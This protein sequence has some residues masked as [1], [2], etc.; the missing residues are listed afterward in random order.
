AG[1]FY[2]SSPSKLT[3]Q[4][5]KYLETDAVKDSAIGIVS[6][7]AGLMYSGRVAGAVYSRI[8]IPRTFILIGPNHTGLG[9]P[10]S[11]MS[12][13]VWHMP[14]GELKIDEDLAGAL[15]KTS[16]IISED[17]LAHRMEHSLEVQLPF[18][19]HFSSDA[20]IVPITMMPVQL[21][22]CRTVGEALADVVR[23]SDY[24][25]TIIASSDMSHYVSDAAAR[26][27]D[28][29]AIDRV[30]A[31]DPEGLYKTVMNEDISM[32]GVIPV[33]TMLFAARKLGASKA[34]LV[35]YM[36]SGEV[37]GDYDY[38]VGYAGIIVR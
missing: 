29:K 23:K 15:K 4:V 30:L 32:C 19:L 8:K 13:G 20:G 28:Q 2:E 21:E 25:V 34:S 3:G 12:S 35:K 11:L 14:T 24:P 6:P 33:T 27:K 38:V 5:N 18:I 26:K 22:V 36:T 17:S 37:S 10:V 16:D 9:S 31:L 7:H 1:Q